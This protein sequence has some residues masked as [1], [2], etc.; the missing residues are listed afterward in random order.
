MKALK[1]LE[2]IIDKCY[3]TE[4]E[5]IREAIAE[6]EERQKEDEY[7]RQKMKESLSMENKVQ[8]LVF[9]ETYQ[10]INNRVSK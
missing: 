3:F 5:E 2:K 8:S 4:V 9:V 10:I 7:M 6:L 1:V